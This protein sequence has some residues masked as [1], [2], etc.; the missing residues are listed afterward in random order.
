MD[1]QIY[2]LITLVNRRDNFH[3]VSK[4]IDCKLCSYLQWV[5]ICINNTLYHVDIGHNTQFIFMSLISTLLVSVYM[6]S[7]HIML[8]ILQYC[9]MHLMVKW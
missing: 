7:V 1:V 3:Y 9:D 4:S 2:T 6:F 5:D 8:P